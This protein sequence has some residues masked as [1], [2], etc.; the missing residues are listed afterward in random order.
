V[1]YS[2]LPHLKFCKEG[3]DHLANGPFINCTVLA[4]AIMIP[5]GTERATWSTYKHDFESMSRNEYFEEGNPPAFSGEESA[6]GEGEHRNPCG[7]H[8]EDGS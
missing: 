3:R 1:N 6:A 2:A 8:L 7:N 5:K 4:I